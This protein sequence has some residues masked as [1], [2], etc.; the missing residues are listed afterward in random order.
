MVRSP[1]ADTWPSSLALQNHAMGERWEPVGIVPTP[2]ARLAGV[3]AAVRATLPEDDLTLHRKKA[4]AH[5]AADEA[6]LALTGFEVERVDVDGVPG[7]LITP[8]GELEPGTLVALHGG[9]YVLCSAATHRRRFAQMGLAARCRVLNVDYRLAP[10]HPFPAAVDDG[11]AALWWALDRGPVVLVGD[12]AGGGLALAVA[13]AHRDCGG[14]RPSGVVAISPW[15]DLT[16][17]GESHRSRRD[18]DPVAHID[19]LPTHASMYLGPTAPTHPLA[20]PVFADYDRM[21][22]LLIQVGSEETLVDDARAVAERAA[23]AHVPVRLEEWSGMFHS[24]HAYA[25]TLH[26]ADEAIA[27]IG[28]WTRAWLDRAP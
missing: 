28:G 10:E 23:A 25:G 4:E 24:W 8:P 17:A 27:V 1:G 11:L 18:R 22:P 15:A 21:P 16:L 26:G 13:L 7:E 9:G 3:V 2:D 20:S 19:D 6:W 5:V 12:S 14:S